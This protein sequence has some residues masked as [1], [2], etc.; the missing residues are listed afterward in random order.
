MNEYKNYFHSTIDEELE[1]GEIEDD[2]DENDTTKNIDNEIKEAIDLSSKVV[3]KKVSENHQVQGGS[4]SKKS[5]RKDKTLQ[6][7]DD[8][9][10]SNIEAQIANVLKKDGVEPPMPTTIR[11]QELDLE[12]DNDRKV[13]RSAGTR[14]RR[15]RK[16]KDHKKE[17]TS[18][19]VI[20]AYIENVYHFILK[21]FLFF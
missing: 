5:S 12:N 21:L 7:E 10:M 18:S 3:E 17:S 14:K 4:S 6:N 2:E 20:R 19:K 11:K 1:D 16:E 15:R 9:F 13:G 8:D